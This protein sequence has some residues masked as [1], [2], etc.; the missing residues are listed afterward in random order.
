MWR[1]ENGEAPVALSSQAC[2][3][4]SG[5]ADLTYAS[6]KVFTGLIVRTFN[7]VRAVSVMSKDYK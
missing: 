4:L 2:I 1:L 6:F 5:A 7:A 3:V